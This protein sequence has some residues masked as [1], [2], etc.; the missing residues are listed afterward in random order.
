MDEDEWI[1]SNKI[2][3]PNGHRTSRVKLPIKKNLRPRQRQIVIQITQ[4]PNKPKYY[5]KKDRDFTAVM[6]IHKN[7]CYYSK[8]K[9]YEKNL[10]KQIINY[11]IA[12]IIID[13]PFSVDE[14]PKKQ[15]GNVCCSCCCV[16]M[17]IVFFMALLPV[18]LKL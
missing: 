9:N 3:G 11:D 17:I 5:T 4:Q 13:V 15:D 14:I 18:F 8:S 7:L 16:V 10:L 1:C 2:T 12:P 6:M